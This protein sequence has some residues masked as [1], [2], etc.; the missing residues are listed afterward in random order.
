MPA[1]Y[2]RLFA[3]PGTA[4]FT[5][6]GLLGRLTM[7]MTGVALVVL[8]SER[9]GSYALAG[10]VAAV[11]LATGAIGMPLLGRLVDRYGQAR[12][13]VPATLYNAVP[14]V[15]LLLCVRFDAPDWTLYACWAACAAAPNLGGMARARWAHLYRD[16]AAARHLANS[17]EQSLDEL[18]FMA[19]PVL[20]MVLCTTVAPE[21]GLLAAGVFGSAGALLFAAQ[22]RTEPPL[23]DRHPGSTADRSGPRP[24]CSDPADRPH[25]HGSP[26]RTPGLRVLLLTFLATGVVFG[27]MELTTVAYADALGHKPLAGGLLALVAGGSCVAGLVFGL[28]RPRRAA[29]VRFLFGVTAM[30][31]LLLLPLAAGLGGAGLVLLGAALFVA[32]TGTA[33]TMV[34]GMTLVQ[35][36][37]PERQL[38]EGMAVAV[39]G[40]VVGISAGAALAGAVAE[41][42]A[43]GTGY[44]LPAGAAS[45]ALLIAVAGRRHLRA[46]AAP[47]APRRSG[48]IVGAAH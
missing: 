41:H 26:L 16:D 37:L 45:L 40:I 2:R 12:V 34:T 31:V 4:A 19:G 18:C 46:P 1:S 39:S 44:W 42:T 29:G 35:E 9:R 14:L 6:A 25:R 10:T 24:E 17:F 20:A 13:T 38:N 32:G 23:A 33:P 22:R 21:A 15:G 11:G 28:L 3:L 48:R 5:L 43:P 30:A 27:S 8:L 47:P 36:L 7:S